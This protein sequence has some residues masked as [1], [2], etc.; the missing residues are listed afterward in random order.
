MQSQNMKWNAVANAEKLTKTI[1]HTLVQNSGIKTDANK[2][3]KKNLLSFEF[4]MFT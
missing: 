1:T 3:K 2:K 4:K